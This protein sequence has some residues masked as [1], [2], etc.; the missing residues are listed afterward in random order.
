MDQNII[1]DIHAADVAIAVRAGQYRHHPAVEAAGEASEIADQPPA[2]TLAAAAVA[3]GL[4]TGR[5]RLIEGGARTFAALF[6]ATRIKSAIKSR[7]VR[8]RPYKLLDEGEYETGLRG[9]DE[10]DYNSFPS[11]H[12]ADAVAAARAV[13]R[14]APDLAVPLYLGAAAIGAIQIP[15][16]THHLADVVAGAAVGLVAEAL[17]DGGVRLVKRGL[18]D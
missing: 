14:V 11:G 9:P 3:L 4:A 5:P 10:R 15:R 12:T 2:F 17:V 16:A 7:V 18:N 6:V 1:D 13:S 8:T